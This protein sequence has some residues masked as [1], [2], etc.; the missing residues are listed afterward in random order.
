M[1]KAITEEEFQKYLD[2][3]FGDLPT[4]TKYNDN[5]YVYEDKNYTMIMGTGALENLNKAL[6]EEIRKQCNIKI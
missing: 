2:E 6:D 1:K 3:S 5:W 4:I